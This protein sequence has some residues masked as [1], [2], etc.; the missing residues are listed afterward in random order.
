M[1]SIACRVLLQRP[2]QAHSTRQLLQ[3]RR[4]ADKHRGAR[5]RMSDVCVR[6]D[7]S[8]TPAS[9][10]TTRSAGGSDPRPHRSSGTST[11]RAARPSAL[12]PPLPAPPHR[13][14][15]AESQM[16]SNRTHAPPVAGTRVVALTSRE[17]QPPPQQQQRQGTRPL[18]TLVRSQTPRSCLCARAR[19]NSTTTGAHVCIH[20][21]TLG[22]CQ[23][24]ARMQT[25]SRPS[26]APAA[27]QSQSTRT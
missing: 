25:H 27:R 13:C 19:K 24:W 20:V 14:A 6:D 17:P 12:S 10:M 26:R 23:F 4:A 11:R 21:G 16:H 22:N 8:G 1:H 15:R 2:M 7:A 5:C 18:S 9:Q 3:V